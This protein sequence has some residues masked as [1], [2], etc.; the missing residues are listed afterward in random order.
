MGFAW[1]VDRPHTVLLEMLFADY[2]VPPVL[3]WGIPCSYWH[4]LIEEV[5]NES[6]GTSE[7]AIDGWNDVISTSSSSGVRLIQR[8]WESSWSWCV[9]WFFNL[10]WTYS[11][12]CSMMIGGHSSSTYA[13][14]ACCRMLSDAITNFKWLRPTWWLIQENRHRPIL[15]WHIT[16]IWT[17]VQWQTAVSHLLSKFTVL[18]F[19]WNKITFDWLLFLACWSQPTCHVSGNVTEMQGTLMTFMI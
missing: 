17:A 15:Q 18:L 4:L 2:W 19:S 6:F 10:A 16:L 14:A 1:L 3:L 13:M 11:I 12:G 5:S 8:E 7:A 9:I